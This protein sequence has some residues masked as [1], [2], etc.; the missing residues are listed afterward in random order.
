ML[1]EVPVWQP[2]MK[3]VPTDECLRRANGYPDFARLVDPAP[4]RSLAC[5]IIQ[6]FWNPSGWTVSQ[7]AALYNHV[8]RSVAYDYTKADRCDA[9][10][11]TTLYRPAH[12]LDLGRGICSDQAILVASLF[13]AVFIPCSFVLVGTPRG[14]H[15]FTAL[16]VGSSDRC[17]NV[18]DAVHQTRGGR[19]GAYRPW[20]FHDV[21]TPATFADTAAGYYLGDYPT[22]LSLGTVF[23]NA[24]RVCWR[25]IIDTYRVEFA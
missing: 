10:L 8:K 21:G 14:P 5:H 18:A 3:E 13:A 1:E 17:E 2:S 22:Q 4:L 15:V 6:P 16:H 20:I 23:E 19:R 11:P 9:H 24:G 12:T 7:A 25:E